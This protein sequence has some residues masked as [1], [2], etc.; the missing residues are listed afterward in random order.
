MSIESTQY[1]F[2]TEEIN[3]PSKG[4]IYPDSNPLSSGKVTIKYPGA[5]Q[6]DILSNQAYIIDGSVLDKYVPS[7][8]ITFPLTAVAASSVS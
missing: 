8:I 7:G 5:R 4:L 3:L 1:D 2:P 6:E